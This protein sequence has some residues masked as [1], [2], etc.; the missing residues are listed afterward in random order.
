[1]EE[2]KVIATEV[3]ELESKEEIVDSS[4]EDNIMLMQ[5]RKLQKLR[6]KKKIPLKSSLLKMMVEIVESNLCLI[7]S[8]FQ[9]LQI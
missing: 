1:M 8:Q 3:E 9:I 5:L 2:D 4:V 7:M 6:L